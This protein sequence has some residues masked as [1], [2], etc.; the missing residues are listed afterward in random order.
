[1]NWDTTGG[2]GGGGGSGSTGLHG[3]SLWAA[4][5]I[6]NVYED[7]GTQ[8]EYAN[9]SN[10]V[11]KTTGAVDSIII[12]SCRNMFTGWQLVFRGGDT[13]VAHVNTWLPFLVNADG[14]KI[15]N[16]S[17]DPTQFVGRKIEPFLGNPVWVTMR[18]AEG[19][20]TNGKPLPDEDYVRRSFEQWLPLE[21]DTVT[22]VN[23][24]GEITQ[25]GAGNSTN[26]RSG[27]G[28]TV[29]ANLNSVVL[30]D[31]FVDKT[32]PRGEYYGSVRA[33]VVGQ[34]DTTSIPV[35]LSVYSPTLSDTNHYPVFTHMDGDLFANYGGTS[36]GDG[37]YWNYWKKTSHLFHRHRMDIQLAQEKIDTIRVREMGYFT[38]WRY[39]AGQGYAGPGVGVGNR[40]YS[41]NLYGTNFVQF[42]PMRM[43]LL[44]SYGDTQAG[45]RS[46]TDDLY[47][48]FS[49][50]LGAINDNAVGG[51]IISLEGIDEPNTVAQRDSMNTRAD[52]VRTGTGTGNKKIHLFMPLEAAHS[53]LMEH[54]PASGYTISWDMPAPDCI[55][56]GTNGYR[57]QRGST[58]NS[59]EAEQI[60]SMTAS[61]SLPALVGTYNSHE[62][63]VPQMEYRDHGLA[64]VALWPWVMPYYDIDYWFLWTTTSYT[65]S[66]SGANGWQTIPDV[67]AGNYLYLGKDVKYAAEN[68][69]LEM[70]IASA[71]IKALRNGLQHAEMIWLAKQAA[72]MD[73]NWYHHAGLYAAFN[74]WLTW[75][76]KHTSSGPSSWTYL[77]GFT[78]EA[79]AKEIALALDAGSGTET[80]EITTSSPLTAGTVGS[81]YSLALGSTGGTAPYAYETLSGSLP[82]GLSLSEAGILSGTPT[83][84][85]IFSFTVQVTDDADATATKAFSLTINVSSTPRAGLL[86]WH[87]I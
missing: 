40:M 4:D 50:S 2:G 14:D 43:Y 72:V 56:D 63:S 20:W 87:R 42:P 34:T 78:V 12:W 18:N 67:G 6:T 45:W 44:G 36:Y 15:E 64:E 52:W 38:G 71:R 58:T 59:Y 33:W 81:A 1:V 51:R 65:Q 19:H 37:N 11:W 27:G 31:V 9:D 13:T 82:G 16:T 25:G 46:A 54:S 53:E 32:I 35:H 83:D 17:N 30:Y 22:I 57:T 10:A 73:T 85:G 5:Q 76:T 23:G 49:D 79:A 48:L 24:D 69:N 74:D 62:G 8:W 47:T 7:Q 41:A 86:P 84:S 29:Q 70:P 80:L 3:I 60:R 26:A 28:F 21:A 68:R 39:T 77:R 66:G 61:D 55:M 75:P